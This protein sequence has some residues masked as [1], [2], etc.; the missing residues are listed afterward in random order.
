MYVMS[1][2][3]TRY[4]EEITI[5]YDECFIFQLTSSVIFKLCDEAH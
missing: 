4:R 2:K 1:E 3:I 5:E